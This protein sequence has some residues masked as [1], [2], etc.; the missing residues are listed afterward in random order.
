[1]TA[2]LVALALAAAPAEKPKLVVLNLSPGAGVA[3]EEA[4]A[5]TEAVTAE[6]AQRG[7]FDVVAASEVQTLLGVERQR[8]VMGCSEEDSCLQELAGALGARFVMSGS[9]GKLGEAY[10]LSLQTLDSKK[11]QPLGRSVRLAQDI[12]ILRRQLAFAVAEATGTPLPPPPSR[13]LP[14]SLMA[15][16]GLAVVGG[17]VLGMFALNHQ[18]ALNRELDRDIGGAGPRVLGSWS[19]YQQEAN[20]IGAQKTWSLVALGVGAGL[21]GAGIY[22]NPP[23]S[24]AGSLALVPS[25]SGFALVGGFR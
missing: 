2:L 20:E 4:N 11:A 12:T 1:M 18:A 22:L 6:V 19:A 9:V 24:G 3:A 10:Q 25:A 5:L 21:I 13:V 16:G 23:D 8:Q 15:S 7:F 14:I 17:A